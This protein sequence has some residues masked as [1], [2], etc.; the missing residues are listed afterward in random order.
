[1][2]LSTVGYDERTGY[3]ANSNIRYAEY[4]DAMMELVD[5]AASRKVETTRRNVTRQASRTG[6][7]PD[8]SSARTTAVDLSK[9][10]SQMSD[11]ELDAAMSKLGLNPKQ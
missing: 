6:L 1:M 5:E 4:V 11:K 8:G 10:P 9:D 2:Y 3:V 7:R